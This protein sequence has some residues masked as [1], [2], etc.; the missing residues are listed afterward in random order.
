MINI[1]YLSFNIYVMFLNNIIYVIVFSIRLIL[2]IWLGMFLM[3]YVPY[4]MTRTYSVICHHIFNRKYNR[5]T[6]DKE[7]MQIS[8]V[9]I[10]I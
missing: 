5:K 1:I 2:F 7:F 6:I 9:I 8:Q 10:C 3:L 4:H